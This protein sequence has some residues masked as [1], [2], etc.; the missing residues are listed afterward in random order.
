MKNTIK[1]FILLLICSVTLNGFSQQHRK[2]KRVNWEEY[3]TQKISFLTEKLEL[4]PEEAQQFWPVYN[5]FEKKRLDLH[6]ERREFEQNMFKLLDHSSDAEVKN[7]LEKH[8]DFQKKDYELN[9][10]YS[11]KI[12]KVLP[13]QKVAKL[14]K[15]EV[16]FRR[17]MMKKYQER[18]RRKTS[19]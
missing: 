8:L 3:K 15:E 11:K 19:K 18:G 13:I 16:N 5:Q 17:H 9:A 12:M 14:I 6:K 4:T 7:M 2:M 1:I 10:A